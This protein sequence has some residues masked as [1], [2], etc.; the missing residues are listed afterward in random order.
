MAAASATTGATSRSTAQPVVVRLYT[1]LYAAF[2]GFVS[3]PHPR[4]AFSPRRCRTMRLRDVRAAM[5]FVSEGIRIPNFMSALLDLEYY[6]I[7]ILRI[8]T[9]ELPVDLELQLAV[10]G[11]HRPVHL[12]RARTAHGVLELHAERLVARRHETDHSCAFGPME[13]ATFSKSSRAACNWLGTSGLAIRSTRSRMPSSS[14]NVLNMTHDLFVS[15]RNCSTSVD[16]GTSKARK[17]NT[18]T[19][20]GFSTI[21]TQRGNSPSSTQKSPSGSSTTPFPS[22]IAFSTLRTSSRKAPVRSFRRSV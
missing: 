17:P 3:Q 10:D 6:N 16:R 15:W 11:D 1:R 21:R 14:Q 7:A 22:Q 9:L 19:A 18:Q 2:R 12:R 20:S 5:R 13:A 4:G 8:L